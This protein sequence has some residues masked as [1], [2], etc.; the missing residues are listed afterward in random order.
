MACYP[1]ARRRVETGWGAAYSPPVVSHV[2]R[3]QIGVSGVHFGTFDLNSVFGVVVLWRHLCDCNVQFA[4]QDFTVIPV[5]FG[6]F[7]GITF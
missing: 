5:Q 4:G 1:E 3:S 7:S 2:C 6:I